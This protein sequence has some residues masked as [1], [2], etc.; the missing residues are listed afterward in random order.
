MVYTQNP[1]QPQNGFVT[2]QQITVYRA[3]PELPQATQA[4]FTNAFESNR[5]Q[6]Q[7]E[8]QSLLEILTAKMNRRSIETEDSM[9]FIVSS[10]IQGQQ[11]LDQLYQQLEQLVSEPEGNKAS[12]TPH[13]DRLFEGV[14]E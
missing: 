8:L 7:Q 2:G 12:V 1:E 11:E 6:R 3:L 9:R 13:L 14:S 10:Q 4:A 5:K